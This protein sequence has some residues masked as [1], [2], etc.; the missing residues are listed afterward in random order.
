MAKTLK[1]GN[2]SSKMQDYHTKRMGPNTAKNRRQMHNGRIPKIRN[3]HNRA[4]A[5]SAKDT[6]TSPNNMVIRNSNIGWK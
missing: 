3:I 6:T 5:E 4:N 1:T 2:E